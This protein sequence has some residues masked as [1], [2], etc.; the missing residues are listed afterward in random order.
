M[1]NNCQHFNRV[2]EARFEK[3]LD[4]QACFSCSANDRLIIDVSRKYLPAESG[5]VAG[6]KVC[7][8]FFQIK[9]YPNRCYLS[10]RMSPIGQRSSDTTICNS[11]TLK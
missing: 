10:S 11:I 4:S 5:E 3:E 2:K 9:F 1:V 8:L 6:Y 7:V